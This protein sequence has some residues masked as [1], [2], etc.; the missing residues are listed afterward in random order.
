VVGLDVIP[1]RVAI[2]VS[3]VAR[4]PRK[5]AFAV[6][7]AP[8]ALSMARARQ[9]ARR[10]VQAFAALT[11]PPRRAVAHALHADSVA[12]ACGW[13]CGVEGTRAAVLA[14]PMRLALA[15]RNCCPSRVAEGGRR[16]C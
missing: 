11:D 12:G 4:V 6:A 13:A 5:S 7:D 10:K 1:R 3:S 16:L 15:V 9:R 2:S 8:A 14:C